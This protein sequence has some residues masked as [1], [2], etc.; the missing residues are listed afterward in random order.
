MQ[1]G[2]SMEEHIDD[3]NKLI[4]DLENVEIKVEDEDRG[5]LAIE[6]SP[7][8]LFELQRCDALWNRC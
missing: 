8:L 4:L 7:R 3:F 6:F 5:P 2:R 1:S